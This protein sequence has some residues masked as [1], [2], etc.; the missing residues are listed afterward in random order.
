MATLTVTTLCA[1]AKAH[2]DN[3]MH[4][5]TP[6][7]YTHKDTNDARARA[8]S[9]RHINNEFLPQVLPNTAVTRPHQLSPMPLTPPL[10]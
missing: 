2:V 10:H 8:K 4:A 3:N 6:N 5:L 7:A 1:T 9:R